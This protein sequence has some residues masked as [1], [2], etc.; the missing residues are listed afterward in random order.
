MTLMHDADDAPC[1]S[2]V[3]EGIRRE[4]HDVTLFPGFDGT[5]VADLRTS[6]ERLL[7]HRVEMAE[8]E[9]AAISAF[10]SVFDRVTCPVN[11]AERVH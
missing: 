8:V 10:L 9:E 7:G 3:I 2:D 4:H 11:A 6:L 5:I 1:V